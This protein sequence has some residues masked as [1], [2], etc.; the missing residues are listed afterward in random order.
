MA[1]YYGVI[2]EI[3]EY[4]FGGDKNL[5]VVFFDCDWFNLNRGMR[6]N[7]FGMVEVKHEDRLRGHDTLI[8]AHQVEQVYYMSYPYTS[9]KNWWVV[10]KVNP[11]E[12]LYAPGE[13]GYSESQ[14]EME[15]GANV[16]FQDDELPSTF[17]IVTEVLAESLIG[18]CDD[19]VVPKKRKRVPRK[20]KVMWRPVN[21][22]KP[23]DPDFEYD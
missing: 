19:V 2:K 18:D 8:L 7:Q 5:K 10:Y 23:L 13:A 6:E 11:R 20:K 1:N 3:L 12:R 14:L 17:N 9:L 21:R 15:V 16:I 22:R 4:R